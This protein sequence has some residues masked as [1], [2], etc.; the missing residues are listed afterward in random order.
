MD[1]VQYFVDKHMFDALYAPWYNTAV[2]KDSRDGKEV[3]S[4]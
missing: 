2:E 3:S 4:E 1:I